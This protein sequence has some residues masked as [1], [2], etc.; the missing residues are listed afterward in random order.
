MKIYM[1]KK[2]ITRILLII[3]MPILCMGV[4]IQP[5]KIS[6]APASK[7]VKHYKK[8]QI[9]AKKYQDKAYNAPYMAKTKEYLGK[10]MKVWDNELNYMYKETKKKISKKRFEKLKKSQRKWIKYRD[11]KAWEAYD[12]EQGGSIAGVSYRESII[13]NTK[14][15]TKWIMDTYL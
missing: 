12:K 15:R 2:F 14:K 13:K 10:A 9:K 5:K 7:Y 4:M 11:K 1:E 6:A 8:V 3:I